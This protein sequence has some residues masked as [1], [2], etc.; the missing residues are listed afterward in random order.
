MALANVTFANKDEILCAYLD[1]EIDHDS[2]Q[3]LRSA[4]DARLIAQRP[5]FLVLDFGQVGFMGSSG[6]GLILGRKRK[7][8]ALGGEVMVQH[9]PEQVEKILKLVKD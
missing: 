9:A 4:I 6:L 5:R 3:Q 2:A 7:M 1:G 8:Q